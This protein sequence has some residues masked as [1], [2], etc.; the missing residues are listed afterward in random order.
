M[1]DAADA[2]ATSAMHKEWI[3]QTLK[4]SGGSC[5]YEKIV[6]VGETKHCDTVGA[7][8][9]FLKNDKIISFNQIFLMYPM[10]KDEIITLKAQE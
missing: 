8:L 9:K 3:I 7:M 6:E 4:D 10:H 2:A 1:A 5:T